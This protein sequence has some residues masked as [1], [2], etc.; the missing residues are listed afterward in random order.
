MEE[1]ET[2]RMPSTEVWKSGCEVGFFV[3]GVWFVCCCCLAGGGQGRY[4]DKR[5]QEL[6][7]N[8]LSKRTL[9]GIQVE[10]SISS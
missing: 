5:Y 7:L 4:G 10:V 2:G 9:L 6:S 1:R 3:L 8:V